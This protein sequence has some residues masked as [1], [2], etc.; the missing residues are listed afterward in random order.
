MN[1]N[2]E[3]SNTRAMQ[4]HRLNKNLTEKKNGSE[5]VEINLKCNINFNESSLLNCRGELI[6][7]LNSVEESKDSIY[8]DVDEQIII[9]FSFLE[10]VILSKFGVKALEI[11]ECSNHREIEGSELS[12]P[13]TVK[14][15]TNLPL[16]DFNEIDDFTPAYSRDFK[17]CDLKEFTEFN[18]PGSK[19]H[20]VKHLTIFIQDNQDSKEKTYLNKIVLLGNI[21][22]S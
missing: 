11:D 12:K 22:P 18:L 2:N 20:R 17:E 8:S 15:Y 9:K 5:N 1:I 13:K 14:I 4:L 21:I 3:A 7:L 16:I 19:F 6:N 10:P